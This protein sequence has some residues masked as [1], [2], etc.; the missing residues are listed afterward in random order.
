MTRPDPRLCTVLVLASLV[1]AGCDGPREPPPGD[2]GS[3][4]ETDSTPLVGGPCTYE[5]IAFRGTVDSVLSDGALLVRTDTVPTPFRRRC[6]LAG[7]PETGRWR[8][9]YRTTGAA[10]SRGDSVEVTA[11][12]IVT[13]A[14]VPCSLGSRIVR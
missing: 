3:A 4:G 12:V 2:G 6:D 5:R 1:L 8:V 10:P 9:P 13:G 11:E 14:C 7:D